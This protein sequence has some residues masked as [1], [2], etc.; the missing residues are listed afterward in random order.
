MHRFMPPRF[1]SNR[2]S[3]QC[4]ASVLLCCALALGLPLA[5]CDLETEADRIA[6][7]RVQESLAAAPSPRQAAPEAVLARSGDHVFRQAQLDLGVEMIRFLSGQPVTADEVERLRR[8]AIRQFEQDP[9]QFGQDMDFIEQVLSGARSTSNLLE[10]ASFRMGLFQTF[11]A[12]NQQLPAS[13]RPALL[14]IVFAKNPV[15]A[16]DPSTQ[17]LLTARDLRG[18]VQI[19]AFGAGASIGEAEIRH[20]VGELQRTLA[21]SFAALSIEEKQFLASAGV[22]WEV[23][24]A[25]LS[26]FSA[27]EV[28]TLRQSFQ[29][30]PTP[31]SSWNGSSGMD[32]DTA[33]F[34]SQLSLQEH[35]STLNVIEN[36]GGSGDYWEVVPAW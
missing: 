26:S 6:D 3:I 34:L 14:E 2:R 9:A 15:L 22:T 29:G 4:P 32:A 31:P 18:A 13:E 27:E 25:N 33:R 19:F 11:Y 8:D 30:R 16:Y 36:L 1:T 23:L 12:L 10:V 35:V 17:L 28:A 5:G 24:E 21:P 7:G 20:H